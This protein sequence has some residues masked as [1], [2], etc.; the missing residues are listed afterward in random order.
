MIL[1]A[2]NGDFTAQVRVESDPF[3]VGGYAGFGLGVRAPEDHTTWLQV[4][5]THALFATENRNG[6]TTHLQ[7]TPD[8]GKSA[9]YLRIQR[10]GGAFT[11]SYSEDDTTWVSLVSDYSFDMPWT[12]ELYLFTFASADAPLS[13]RFSDFRLLD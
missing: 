10:V 7:N 11:L 13:A 3:L 5:R 6:A 2:K 4:V 1:T 8:Y 12:T 9:V